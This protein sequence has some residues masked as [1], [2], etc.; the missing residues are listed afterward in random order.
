M[1]QPLQVNRRSFMAAMGSLA[2]AGCQTN[3]VNTAKVLRVLTYNLHHGEGTDGVVNLARIAKVVVSAQPDLVALQEVDRR[4]QRTGK[5]DQSAEYIRLIGMQGWYGAAMPF[6]GGEYGQLLL[7]RWPLLDPRVIRLPGTPGR[8]PRIA[9][10]SWVDVPGLGRIRWSG[11]HLDATSED[12]DRWE[13]VGALLREFEHAQEPALLAGDFNA[14]PDSRVMRRM[15]DTGTGWLDTA[16]ATSAPTSPADAPRSRIDYILARPGDRW[17]SL[18]SKVLP[19]S[20]A[21]DHRPLL[22][23][24]KAE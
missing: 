1:L 8:E 9:V 24:L 17:R 19:E 7:S 13:Q 22:A 12:K 4:A 21:S 11:V 23:V 3:H 18:E 16:G 10:T 15:L 2:V 6:Q 14:T 5:V 20:V